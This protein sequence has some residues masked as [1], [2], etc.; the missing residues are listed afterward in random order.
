MFCLIA[1]A[2]S[3]I[4]TVSVRADQIAASMTGFNITGSGVFTVGWQFN[5]LTPIEVT[6]LGWMGQQLNG[7]HQVAIWASSGG[8]PL[9]QTTVLTTDPQTGL[10]RYHSVAPVTLGV[11]SYIIGGEND[12]QDVYG[13]QATGFSTAPQIQYVTGRFESGAGLQFPTQIDAGNL[14]EIFGPNFQ[15]NVVPAP[16]GVVLAGM[17]VLGLIGMRYSRRNRKLAV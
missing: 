10:F 11:G 15:F 3:A 16:A 14:P 5:V 1:L 12:A 8:S 4:G 7:N 2:M 13:G 9:V 6:Q 17:G